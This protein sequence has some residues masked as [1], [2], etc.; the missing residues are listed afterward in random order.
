MQIAFCD[1]DIIGAEYKPCLLGRFGTVVGTKPK[2]EKKLSHFP[3]NNF[4][5]V[6]TE[7]QQLFTCFNNKKCNFWVMTT[8]IMFCFVFLF[9]KRAASPS[10]IQEQN[11][12]KER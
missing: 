9:S 2:R 7:V 12:L 1:D 8:L 3:N 6:S 4:R 5:Q 11:K 10:Y